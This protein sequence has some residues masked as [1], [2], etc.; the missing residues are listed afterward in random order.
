MNTV[1]IM[2]IMATIMTSIM[3]FN[4]ITIKVLLML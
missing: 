2:A 3:A 4:I 1:F